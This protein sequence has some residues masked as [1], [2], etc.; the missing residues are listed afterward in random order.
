MSHAASCQY[1][2]VCIRH[3]STF[4]DKHLQAFV[5]ASFRTEIVSKLD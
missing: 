2:F 4:T 1:T 5:T 3:Y